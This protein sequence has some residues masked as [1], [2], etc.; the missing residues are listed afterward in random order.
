MRRRHIV[1][2]IVEY[3][4]ERGFTEPIIGEHVNFKGSHFRS[5]SFNRSNYLNVT[6]DVFRKNFFVLR[7]NYPKYHKV[8]FKHYNDLFLV[9]DRL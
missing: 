8:P 7:T 2:K 5:V 3:A 1:A 4:K 9:L 6:V